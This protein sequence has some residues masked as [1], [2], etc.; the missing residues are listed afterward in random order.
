MDGKLITSI[1]VRLMKN[2]F[3]PQNIKYKW[4][5]SPNGDEETLIIKRKGD[6]IQV[7]II[8]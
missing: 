1:L 3:N 2:R 8:Q 5:K 4:K 7:T 6:K